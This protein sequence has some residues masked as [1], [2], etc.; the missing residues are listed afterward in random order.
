MPTILVAENDAPLRKMISEIL[1]EQGYRVLSASSGDDATAVAARSDRPIDLL[2][3]D[4]VM[5]GMGGA[6]LHA[7]LKAEQPALRVLFISGFMSREPLEGAFLK[8]PFSV[9][10]LVEK[11]RAVLAQGAAG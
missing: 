2:V 3:T 11:V 6:D 8:K 5:T 7:W 10:E 9:A 4:I 1:R